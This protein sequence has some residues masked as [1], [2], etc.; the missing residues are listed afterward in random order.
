MKPED[1]E[2]HL[3]KNPEAENQ[4]SPQS[5]QKQHELFLVDSSLD[6]L[7]FFTYPIVLNWACEGDFVSIIVSI[8]MSVFIAFMLQR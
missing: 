1:K 4:P 8:N 5:P 2:E 7:C 3:G 6:I